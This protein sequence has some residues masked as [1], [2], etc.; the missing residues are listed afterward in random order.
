MSVGT[1]VIVHGDDPALALPTKP[2]GPFV[3]RAAA[4]RLRAERGWVMVEDAGRGYRRVVPS[5]EPLG[6]LEL[7][8]IR[9]LRGPGCW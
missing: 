4:E 3:D 2:I 7:D 5:P 6:L 1:H 8:T 9:T